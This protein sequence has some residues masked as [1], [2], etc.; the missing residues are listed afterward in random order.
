MCKTS[1]KWNTDNE[2]IVFFTLMLDQCMSNLLGYVYCT[3]NMGYLS[4]GIF[5][6]CSLIEIEFKLYC[7]YIKKYIAYLPNGSRDNTSL[8]V[9]QLS[10][11]SLLCAFCCISCTVAR[12]QMHIIKI[13][14]LLLS[15]NKCNH[16]SSDM[17]QLSA[18]FVIYV[19]SS[20]ACRHF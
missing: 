1:H 16:D 2:T 12:T 15:I 20:L 7:N 10:N 18:M 4:C 13:L 5:S 9:G 19:G 14:M 8:T 6:N 3:N 17:S 11:T